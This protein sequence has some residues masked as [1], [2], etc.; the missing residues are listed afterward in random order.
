M[1][2]Y[3]IVSTPAACTPVGAART[4][5][6]MVPQDP[7]VAACAP[8]VPDGSAA[9]KAAL[10]EAEPNVR[11]T[12]QVPS[13]MDFFKHVKSG[14]VHGCK[15]GE[16]VFSYTGVEV[17]NFLTHVSAFLFTC[18]LL[19]RCAN[20]AMTSLIDSTAQFESQLRDAGLSTA[21]IESRKR[22]GVRTLGQ[23]AFAIGQPGQP[24]QDNSVEQ[25]V[26]NAAGRPPTL[27]ETACVKRAAFEA[28]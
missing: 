28:S 21:L 13:G 26:Q 18:H 4:P 1:K 11:Y 9:V 20:S 2:E 15:L 23:L 8:V 5:V 19:A 7:P 17:L 24:I 3:G 10:E 22:H 14:I 16:A 6:P 12:E 25:L 27:Q